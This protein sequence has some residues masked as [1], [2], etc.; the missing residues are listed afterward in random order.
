MQQLVPGGN[1]SAMN[2]LQRGDVV[3]VKFPEANAATG[4]ALISGWHMAAVVNLEREVALVV[5]ISSLHRKDG[6]QKQLSNTDLAMTKAD[7]PFLKHDSF[8]KGHQLRAA[9]YSWMNIQH[10][11]V[12]VVGRLHQ[13]L[14]KPF[15]HMLIKALHLESFVK[16]LVQEAKRAPL[17]TSHAPSQDEVH[18]TRNLRR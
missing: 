8:L 7:H 4:N 10:G 3:W 2:D 9:S 13:N 5:P 15:A 18:K 11:R 17:H 16:E 1:V 6:A 14:D 12:K